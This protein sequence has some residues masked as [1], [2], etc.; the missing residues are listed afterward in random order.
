[1][2]GPLE[3]VSIK[4]DDLPSNTNNSAK[5]PQQIFNELGSAFVKMASRYEVEIDQGTL[6]HVYADIVAEGKERDIDYIMNQL[7]QMT[8]K[9]GIPVMEATLKWRI[10]KMKTA[11]DDLTRKLAATKAQSQSYQET[12]RE[13]EEKLY[14]LESDRTSKEPYETE[15]SILES[16]LKD[17]ITKSLVN[18]TLDKGQFSGFCQEIKKTNDKLRQDTLNICSIYGNDLWAVQLKKKVYKCFDE[19]DNAALETIFKEY[20]ALLKKHFKCNLNLDSTNLKNMTLACLNFAKYYAVLPDWS[21]IPE[22]KA[23]NQTSG[24]KASKLISKES[25]IKPL[26]KEQPINNTMPANPTKSLPSGNTTIESD[27]TSKEPQPLPRRQSSLNDQ[28][29]LSVLLASGRNS[30]AVSFNSFD[31]KIAATPGNNNPRHSSVPASPVMHNVK[32][33]AKRLPTLDELRHRTKSEFSLGS[34]KQLEKFW[35]RHQET[36]KGPCDCLLCGNLK[37][38]PLFSYCQAQCPRLCY[39][40]DIHKSAIANRVKCVCPNCKEEGTYLS[41]LLAIHKGIVTINSIE[42]SQQMQHSPK[43]PVHLSPL[44]SPSPINHSP[45][46]QLAPTP[47]ASPQQ[48]QHQGMNTGYGAQQKQAFQRNRLPT[49]SIEQQDR[50]KGFLNKLKGNLFHG[51]EQNTK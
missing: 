18:G 12:F 4:Y 34:K 38:A 31:D 40:Q 33:P 10:E 1:M 17:A 42:R 37:Q 47:V 20:N 26:Q 8:T 35:K 5:D 28:R 45:Q 41:A 23:V 44:P 29:P 15:L 9:G 21:H 30:S 36:K 6:K 14:D 13:I 25:D 2:L 32:K 19:P 16:N 51:N 24:S 43:P 46:Q 50:H 3:L 39:M 11:T 49:S 22:E 27:T 48:L 7:Q